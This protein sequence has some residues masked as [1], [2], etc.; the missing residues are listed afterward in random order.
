MRLAATLTDLSIPTVLAVMRQALL[1]FSLTAMP[2]VMA[3]SF[4][5]VLAAGAQTRFL[6][7]GDLLKFKWNRISM[8][9]GFKRMF[10]LRSVVQL[11]KS[12][13]KVGVVLYII[14]ASIEDLMVVTPDILNTGMQETIQFMNHRIMSLVYKICLIFIAVAVLDF[15]YEKYDYE[16]KLMMTKQ[17]IKDEYKQTEGDPFIKGKIKE[18]QRKLSMN[19]MIQQVPQAD[20][21]VRNPTHFAVALKYD[22]SVDRAPL[23]LAK[24]QDLVAMRILKV[25]EENHLLIT[26]NK[27]LAR[28]LYE[29]VEINE[30]VSQD[31]YQMVAEVMAWVY[32]VKNKN[33]G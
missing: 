26:E 1:I 17:E 6:I 29:S 11:I 8:L 28:A 7:S 9:Q 12:L 14:Y 30:Y 33:K 13:I 3:L 4:V 10:S 18:K 24:G 31:L 27:P 22:P 15:A 25:A 5:A 16:K 20:V 21:I 2:I 32:S 19:R 23:V